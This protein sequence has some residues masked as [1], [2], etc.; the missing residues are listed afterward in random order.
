MKTSGGE[1][2]RLVFDTS[3]YSQ[4]RRGHGEVL[5][6]LAAVTLVALPAVVLGELEGGFALGSRREEN[7]RELA[8]FL[9]EPFVEVTPLTAAVARRYGE[10][11]ARLRHAGTP[12]P[13]ND[14]W[15]AACTVETGGEL[16]TFDRHFRH[17]EGLEIRRLR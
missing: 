15:I 13:T 10:I 7:R 9:A 14:L 12:I 17:V 11:Y 2:G 8:E 6:T 5:D 4:M 3:A 1:G 16:L